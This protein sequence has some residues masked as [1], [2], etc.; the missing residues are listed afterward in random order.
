MQ[1]DILTMA[2]RRAGWLGQAV[3]GAPMDFVPDGVQL[4][5]SPQAPVSLGAGTN[6]DHVF[7]IS[8]SAVQLATDRPSVSFQTRAQG[9]TLTTRA[10][11]YGY[12]AFA[13]A[14]RPEGIGRITGL[15]TP[16]FS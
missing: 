14:A 8:R 1:P 2:A 12:L 9:T 7:F 16:T 4:V 15:T 6:E 5:P 11:I 3:A 10:L 13:T